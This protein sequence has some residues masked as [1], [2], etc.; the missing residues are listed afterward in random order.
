[1]LLGLVAVVV[2]IVLIVVRPGA[3]TAGRETPR[4]TDTASTQPSTAPQT[5]KDACN[6]AVLVIE[7]VLDADSYQPG[8]QPQLS[9]RVTN[10]GSS[11]CTLAVGAD[12]LVFSIVSGSDP[13]WT[14][15]DCLTTPEFE[16]ELQPGQPISNSA[17]AWD[18]TRSSPDTCSTSRPEVVAGGATYRLNV[19]VGDLEAE[20]D[21]P[22]LLN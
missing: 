6:P 12:Q 1:M 15:S 10:T 22:F 18:R 21:A 14:S 2:I 9:V 7:P 5:G 11:A 16:L 20:T 19:S 8:E 17:I 13:I 4:P 3:D